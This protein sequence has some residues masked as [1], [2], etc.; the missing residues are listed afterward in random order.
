MAGMM[1][2][3]NC[4]ILSM[5]DKLAVS[6]CFLYLYVIQICV[7][8]SA[9]ISA[10]VQ[11]KCVFVIGSFFEVMFSDRQQRSEQIRFIIDVLMISL[12]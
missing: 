2:V 6:W 12:L 1:L 10:S 8:M 9:C 7:C 5:C 3:T 11:C 4:L